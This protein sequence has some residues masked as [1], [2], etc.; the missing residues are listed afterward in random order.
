MKIRISGKLNSAVLECLLYSLVIAQTAIAA[1][2]YKVLSDAADFLPHARFFVVMIYLAVLAW[3]F[4]QLNRIHAERK[5]SGTQ[6]RW[7]ARG[8]G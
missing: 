8:R 1:Y 2:A 7:S 6:L 4:L 5:L 3:V